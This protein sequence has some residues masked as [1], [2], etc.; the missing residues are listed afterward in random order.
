LKLSKKIYLAHLILAK[1]DETV[2]SCENFYK[3]SCG[4]FIESERIA[5]D[6]TKKDSFSTLTDKLS[7]SIIGNILN[8]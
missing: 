8:K 3:F 2:D 5:E 7:A 4:S 1:L 6:K